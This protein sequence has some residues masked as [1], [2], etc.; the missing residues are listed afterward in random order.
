MRRA[1]ALFFFLG[2]ALLLVIG[3]SALGIAAFLPRGEMSDA[4]TWTPPLEQIDARALDP[5]TSL[6]PLTGMEAA[7]AL[8][9]MLDA[10]HWEN[11]YALIAYDP[12]LPDPTR[13]GA[14]LQLGTRYAATKDVRRAA[15]CYQAAA[16]IATLSPMLS[17]SVRVDT[18]LQVAVGLRALNGRDAARLAIDQAYLVTAYTPTLPREARARR[19]AQVADAYARLDLDALAAQARAKASEYATVKGE[20]GV[21]LPREPFVIA[22][23]KLPPSTEVANAMQTRLAAAQQLLE[24]AQQNPLQSAADLPQ[25]SLAQLSDALR[26]EDR[27]RFAY[28]DQEIARAK[29]PVAR[30]AL[31]HDRVN[32]LALKYRVARGAF[33]VVLVAEWGKNPAAIADAWSDAWGDLLRWYEAQAAAIPNAQAVSQAMEDVLR[34]EL[35]ALRWG[36]YRGASEKELRAALREVTQKLR[37]QSI[38]SLRLD[39]LNRDGKMIDWLVPDEL[40]GQGEKALPR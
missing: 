19:L 4:L 21:S 10:G 28:Y 23:G 26:Q 14:L 7:R 39:V 27:A 12:T 36:W 9:A 5:S 13:I 16:R 2:G 24:D 22:S 35:L 34:Q 18:Y 1:L 33:G 3:L 37:E 38:T 17:D 30:A 6:L 40:Y 29:E 32:W 11:A 25:D 8:D 31:L 15:A 20:E